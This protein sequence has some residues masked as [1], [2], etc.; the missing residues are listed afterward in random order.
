MLH[1]YSCLFRGNQEF[2]KYL[3]TKDAI[4]VYDDEAKP[5]KTMQSTMHSNIIHNKPNR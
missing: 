5:I 3:K 1:G 4:I 2:H